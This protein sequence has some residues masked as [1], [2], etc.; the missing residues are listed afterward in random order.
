MESKNRWY[1]SGEALLK[2]I[3]ESAALPGTAQIWYMGQH[4]FAFNLEGLVFYIDVIL[5]AL[6]GKDG[7]DRRNY[8]P[9]FDP[10]EAQRVDYYICTHNHSD[11]LNLKTILPLA[12]ANLK[13]KFI[14][15]K[16]CVKIL[17]EAGIEENRVLGARAGEAIDIPSMAS[18]NQ[19]GCETSIK[20]T[21]VPAVHT[22]FIQDEGEKDEK[23]DNCA[24]G[25]IIKTGSLSIYHPG[26]TWIT[27]GLADL[28]K[29]EGPLDL[30][31]LPINGTDWERTSYGCIGNVNAMDAVKLAIAAPI[32]LIIPCH[33]DMMSD[34]T[35]NPAYFVDCMY[36]HCPEKR[37]HICALGERFIYKK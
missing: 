12:K 19:N 11:H 29:A 20:V 23:G 30:A 26:D 10:G 1:K 21:P 17:L 5:N 36:R 25:Y 16:P 37:F 8:P 32:D 35:E 18:S 7:K 34:N 9:P 28:L 31:V 24:L 14:V 3:K 2:E 6:P 27:P 33:Y 15:P 13:A 22:R 4:G